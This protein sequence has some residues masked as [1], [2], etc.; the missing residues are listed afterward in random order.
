MM[1]VEMSRDHFTTCDDYLLG[2]QCI[3]PIVLDVRGK[4][5]EYKLRVYSQLNEGQKA[6]FSFYVYFNHAKNSLEEFIW[7]TNHF[8]SQ[9]DVWAELKKGLRY[10]NLN[11]FEI[12]IE[13]F[14]E[15]ALERS[16]YD[17]PYDDPDTICNLFFIFGDHITP[18]LQQISQYIKTNPE[19]FVVLKE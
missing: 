2:W 19:E 10:L 3:E 7:W 11:R 4:D 13:K 5:N 9:S 8:Y 16:K 1:I 12:F 18:T 14:E 17:L 15:T 6:L